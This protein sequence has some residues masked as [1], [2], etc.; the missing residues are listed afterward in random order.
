MN[1]FFFERVEERF[2]VA[3]LLV[4]DKIK[5]IIIK[6]FMFLLVMVKLW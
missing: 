6:L 2:V 1:F 5:I 4:L 3:S